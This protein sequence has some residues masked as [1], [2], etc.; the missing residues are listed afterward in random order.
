MAKERHPL[1][2]MAEAER[3][4]ENPYVAMNERCLLITNFPKGK[5]ITE[6]YIQ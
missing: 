5:R 6:E 4:R 3:H 1:E 2:Y